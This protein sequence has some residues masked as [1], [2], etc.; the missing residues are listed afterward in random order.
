MVVDPCAAPLLTDRNRGHRR[1][2]FRAHGEGSGQTDRTPARLEDQKLNMTTMRTRLL[3]SSMITGVAIAVASQ[4]AHAATAD[5]TATT[6]AAD[7]TAVQELVVTGSRIP[8]K[9]LTSVSPITMVDNRE[10]KLTGT[11]N[12]EDFLNNL[13]QVF[14]EQGQ[15]ESN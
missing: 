2:S 15:Y 10:I 11:T 5:A 9:N 14:A 1:D 7:T 4:G 12:V 13:P 8:T 3:A 6:T